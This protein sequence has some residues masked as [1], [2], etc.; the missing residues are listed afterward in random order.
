MTELQQSGAGAAG[1][2]S[3]SIP[4]IDLGATAASRPPA[5]AVKG[6][7][8]VCEGIGFMVISGH[9]VDDDVIRSM[10]DVSREFFRLDMETKKSYRYP[11]E[12]REEHAANRFRGY[13]GGYNYIGQPPNKL[14]AFQISWFEDAQAMLDAGYAREFVDGFAPNIWPSTPSEFQAVWRTYFER[15]KSL[16]DY[17]LEIAALAL[18]LPIDWFVPKFSRQS[19]YLVANYYPPQDGLPDDSGER[20]HP[21]SDYGA[22]TILYQDVDVGGLEVQCRDGSWQRVPYVPGTFIVNLGD[23]LAK[24]TNDKWVAT[25]HRVR[26][27]EPDELGRDR[28]SVPFF[29]HPNL[30]TMIET[31]PTCIAPGDA[32]H[33]APVLWRD[34]GAKRIG[35]LEQVS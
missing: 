16:G 3:S 32:A 28:V 7:A 2:S 12:R 21:H 17:L 31:I 33:H 5:S 11:P 15:V 9:G 8:D 19:S 23:L 10:M 13:N 24:W 22:F 25:P 35:Q 18:E 30:D 4:V 29:Q 27:P 14:E 6:V 20:L 34:W 1:A 26:Q